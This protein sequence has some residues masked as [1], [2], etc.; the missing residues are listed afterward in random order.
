LRLLYDWRVLDGSKAQN[1]NGR[2]I[3]RKEKEKEDIATRKHNLLR[4]VVCSM[5]LQAMTRAEAPSEALH[6]RNLLNLQ[7]S[8]SSAGTG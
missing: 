4:C 8:I 1:I 3:G 7:R 2:K 6:R 5:R